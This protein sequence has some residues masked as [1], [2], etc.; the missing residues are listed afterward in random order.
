M[1]FKKGPTKILIC[2]ICFSE[3][4]N[5]ELPASISRTGSFFHICSNCKHVENYNYNIKTMENMVHNLKRKM[6]ELKLENEGF[7]RII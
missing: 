1:R 6:I 4:H 2:D 3:F 5:K 7:I